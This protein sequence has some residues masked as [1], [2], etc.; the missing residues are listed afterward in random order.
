MISVNE[1][2]KLLGKHDKLCH[3][4][5]EIL[6]DV[7]SH[8]LVEKNSVICSMYNDLKEAM[9]SVDKIETLTFSNVDDLIRKYEKE[10]QEDAEEIDKEIDEEEGDGDTGAGIFV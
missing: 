5:R 2:L 6:H 7:K 4:L 3:K 1:Y 10:S 8:G 9:T